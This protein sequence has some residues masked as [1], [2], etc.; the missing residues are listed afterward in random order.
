MLMCG[1][2]WDDVAREGLG[3]LLPVIMKPLPSSFAQFDATETTETT[4]AAHL[5]N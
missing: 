4:D 3:M 1:G 5:L 2:R